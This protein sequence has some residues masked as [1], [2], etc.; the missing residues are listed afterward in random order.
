MHGGA[1]ETSAARGEEG[2][3]IGE[4]RGGWLYRRDM[5]QSFLRMYRFRG[6]DTYTQST[7]E[8]RRITRANEHGVDSVLR[9]YWADARSEFF[10]A[11]RS[12]KSDDG[13]S[14]ERPR[15]LRNAHR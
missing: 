10:L 4:R 7:R 1:I 3:Y 9:I 2:G 8:F 13:G 12:T 6:E 15:A 14:R 11:P 5:E